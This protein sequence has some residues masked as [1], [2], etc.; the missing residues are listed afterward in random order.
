MSLTTAKELRDRKISAI[1][2]GKFDLLV[3]GGG[4]TGAGIAL[5][6]AS[7]GI[8]T[9]LI[10]KNDYASG[11]SSK[12]TKLI[13][14][15]LRYLKN[16]E[17]SLVKEVGHE[18]EVVW[19][20][21]PHLV[22]PE[23]MLLPLVKKGS[24]SRLGASIGIYLYDY[25]AGV[26]A[27][28]RRKMLSAQETL[29]REPMLDPRNVIGGALYT[30]YR[31]DDARLTIE[32]VKTAETF[33]AHTL[34]YARAGRPVYENG[35]IKG[36]EVTDE[37]S[38]ETFSVTAQGVINA[39][40]PWVDEIRQSDGSL[41][42]K[43]LKLSKGIHL[44][45][46]YKKLPVNESLYFDV[47]GDKGRMI[48]VIPR[49]RAVYAGTTDTFYDDAEHPDVTRDDVT[50]ILQAV[51]AMFPEARLTEADV[52]ST[53]SGVRPLIMEAGKS[54]SELSRKDELFISASGLVSIAGGKL[55]GYR[56]MAER[57]ID[58]WLEL[59]PELTH[60]SNCY[61]K[62]IPLVGSQFGH[63]KTYLENLYSTCGQIPHTHAMLDELFEKYGSDTEK[64]VAYAYDIYNKNRDCEQ[65]LRQAEL[66]YAVQYEQ[67]VKPAD[68]FI[69][70]TGMLYFNRPKIGETRALLDGLWKETSGLDPVQA[71]RFNAEFE[72]ACE[73]VLQFQ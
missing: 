68:F 41:S 5:D 12:S 29:K 24:L 65:P 72:R 39:A 16:F 58:A 62:K 4:V 43:H 60:I 11:T 35:K 3:I 45:F 44:V 64:I 28:E 63:K 57:S 46:P 10:E 20:N 26:K 47:A 49:G 15:G 23:K 67:V 66:L 56:K 1:K 37:V 48:F 21:A 38:G 14:G 25:L 51:N 52:E 55:T 70:R 30:E 61:T 7:R 6:A 27:G 59:H 31:T 40:G 8:R 69:R 13:H 54:A 33:G 42:G 71:Q 17:F 19:R 36:F 53:W 73:D 18:R 22:H 9:V 32:L 50:Y 34:N 2:N